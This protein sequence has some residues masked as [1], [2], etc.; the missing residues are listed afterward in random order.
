MPRSPVSDAA[1]DVRL[2]IRT[3]VA[4]R[5]EINHLRGSSSVS[6]YLRGLVRSDASRRRVARADRKDARA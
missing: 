2:T 5:D 3:T 6:D 4:E 1:R